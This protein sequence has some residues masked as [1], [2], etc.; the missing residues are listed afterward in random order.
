MIRAGRLALAASLSLGASLAAAQPLAVTGA[1]VFPVSSAPIDN[2]TVL[3]TDGK[4]VAVGVD[5]AI[6]PDARRIDARG[7]WVTPGFIHPAT[8]LGVLEVDAV[9]G[10]DDS[11]AAGDRG[12]AAAFRAWEALNPASALWAPANRDGVTHAVVLPGLG[13]GGSAGQAALVA[14]QAALVETLVG[15]ATDMVRQAPVAMVAS[16]ATRPAAGA[17]SRGEL[18]LRLRE[19]FEDARLFAE[20]PAAFEGNS[21]RSLAAGRVHLAALQPVLAGTLPLMVRAD[22]AADIHA[23]LQ[24]AREFRLKLIV[25]GGAEAWQAADA[26]AA[27]RVPVLTGGLTD[28]PDSFD[29][30]AATL[31]NAARLRQA[32]VPVALTTGGENN[33]RVRTIRQHAGNAV[34]N[35][36]PWAEALRA[37]TLTPAEIFG[38]AGHLGS[39]QPGRDATLVI[40][41]GDPFELATRAERVLVRGRESNEPTREQRLLERYLPRR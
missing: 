10:T 17:R 37:V 25:L 3:M 41:D 20:K 33:F 29:E 14:G 39:L 12:V 40:W 4:I 36:L 5:V 19:L 22:R 34:A 32:G 2:A 31:E 1:R 8:S 15:P 7:K 13:G 11:E 9:A 6:P 16:L 24:F 21:L 38:A 27:A 35:G 23:L 28:L 26:L 18:L 30:L